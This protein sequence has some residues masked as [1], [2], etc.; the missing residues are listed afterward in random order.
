[1][2]YMRMREDIITF[3][4]PEP[5]SPLYIELAGMSWC[6]GSYRIRR[7][8]SKVAVV[9]YVISG[10]GHVRLGDLECRPG[11]GDVYLLPAGFDQDY[12]ADA[13]DPWVKMWFNFGGTLLPQ[14]LEAYRLNGEH[15]F[16]GCPARRLFERGLRQLRSRRAAAGELG[17]PLIVGLM[18]FLSRHRR[19]NLRNPYSA[20]GVAIRDFLE[21]N[22]FAPSP[23]LETIAG[24]IDRSPSQTIRIFKRDFGVTP[25]DYLLRRKMETARVLLGNSVRSVRAIARELGFGDEYYFS[26]LFKQKTGVAP[27]EYRHGR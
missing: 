10:R 23:Q 26:R 14:L 2:D 15:H 8:P 5:G 25:Y 7:N 11:A 13:A 3:P 4:P 1:M 19:S 24:I 9:E 17:P 27:T 18:A 16:E 22:L 20:N 6:D 12:R 21:E